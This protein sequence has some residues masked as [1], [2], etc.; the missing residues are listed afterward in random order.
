[1]ASTRERE[2]EHKDHQLELWNNNRCSKTHIRRCLLG[3]VGSNHA[4]CWAP[5][6][7]VHNCC[8]AS[9]DNY[10]TKESSTDKNNK[11][12]EKQQKK[13]QKR[14][15][16]RRRNKDKSSKEEDVGHSTKFPPAHDV[17]ARHRNAGV[18]E[19]ELQEIIINQVGS[20]PS[21]SLRRCWA[22]AATCFSLWFDCTGS[23]AAVEEYTLSSASSACFCQL[24]QQVM[25]ERVRVWVIMPRIMP[26][27]R[28]R[29][30]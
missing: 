6:N 3:H 8:I 29:P 23:V 9:S 1:M 20:S 21:P 13:K 24:V 5:L 19:Q 17:I 15:R 12:K 7:S 18:R 14:R 22:E 4:R 11:Q 10:L 25:I 26:N 27:Q 28:P 30:L 2:R 16:R